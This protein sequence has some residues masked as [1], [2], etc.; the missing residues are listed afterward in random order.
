MDR[1][2]RILI[3]DD[4]ASDIELA[5]Q[6][7]RRRGMIFSSKAGRTQ[8][9]FLKEVTDF[10]PDVIICDYSMPQFNALDALR[11]LKEQQI[12]LDIPFVV[13]AGSGNEEVAVACLQ[14]GADDYV[15][16]ESIARLS[17][18]IAHAIEKRKMERERKESE[19]VLRNTNKELKQLN[20]IMMNREK[21]I[22]E[23]KAE[24]KRLRAETPSEPE[25]EILG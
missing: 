16:K 19:T 15:I 20:E 17:F 4:V 10:A 22:L 13:L 5:K 6:E 7:L 2:L 25:K 1:E 14:E 8:Q 9:F 18:A 3:L 12:G 24:I 23:L 11:L 21:R